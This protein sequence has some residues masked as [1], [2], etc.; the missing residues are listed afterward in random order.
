LVPPTTSRSLG[1][2][3]FHTCISD[4]LS[5]CQLLSEDHETFVKLL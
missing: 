1:M 2:E 3:F 4:Q 5:N